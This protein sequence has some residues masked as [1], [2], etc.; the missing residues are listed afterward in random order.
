MYATVRISS[1]MSE[2]MDTFEGHYC[3]DVSVILK[4]GGIVRG[5]LFTNP[6]IPLSF[7][8]I[9]FPFVFDL[10]LQIHHL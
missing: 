10:Y 4:L 7:V 8:S 3:D 9:H 2:K 6:K 5:F 1:I